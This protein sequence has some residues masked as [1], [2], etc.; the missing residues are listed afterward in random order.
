L[1]WEQTIILP[2]PSNTK[3][4]CARIKNLIDL[5]CQLQ[6]KIQQEMPLQPAKMSVS[7]IDKEFLKDLQKVI[8]KNI[9]N[10]EFNV[11]KLC[12]ELYMSRATLYRK[13]HALSG[14]SPTEF[15]TI[16]PSETWGSFTEKEIRNRS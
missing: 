9:S 4:L 6:Q 13:I 7:K 5:R 8:R 16:I 14:E 2:S 12:R 1:R 11:E 15:Y 3:I 10:P